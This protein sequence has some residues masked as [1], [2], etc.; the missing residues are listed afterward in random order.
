MFDIFRVWPEVLLSPSSEDHQEDQTV[1]EDQEGRVIWDNADHFMHGGRLG[2]ERRE[3]PTY[4]KGQVEVG[5]RVSTYGDSRPHLLPGTNHAAIHGGHHSSPG[6]SL[7]VLLA[8]SV[9]SPAL[10]VAWARPVE[11]FTTVLPFTKRV[12]KG[13]AGKEQF[14][15]VRSSQVPN[16][17]RGL[18][19]QGIKSCFRP[20]GRVVDGQATLWQVGVQLSPTADE[21]TVVGRRR[22]VSFCH[23]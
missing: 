17:R 9:V 21:A 16:F 1:D 22:L 20:A 23:S 3:R 19:R 10:G 5:N 13:A 6:F 12:L 2:S 11:I 15:D 18:C 4:W 14:L 8:S 7:R